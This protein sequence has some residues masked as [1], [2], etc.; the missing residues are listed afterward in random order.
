MLW[1]R[2]PASTPAHSP[3]IPKRMVSSVASPIVSAAVAAV[4]ATRRRGCRAASM[5]KAS[6]RMNAVCAMM[7]TISRL[8]GVP[9]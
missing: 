5:T 3:T 1:V 8:T 2:R 7:N 4:T 6:L 9:A